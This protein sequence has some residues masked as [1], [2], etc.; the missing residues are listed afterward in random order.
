[1]NEDTNNKRLEQSSFKL[2]PNAGRKDG[3]Q[4]NQSRL[5]KGSQETILQITLD[6]IRHSGVGILYSNPSLMYRIYI[7]GDRNSASRWTSPYTGGQDGMSHSFGNGAQQIG[8]SSYTELDHSS[9]INPCG[10]YRK[11][12]SC[13]PKIYGSGVKDFKFNSLPNP[14]LSKVDA[15]I[16][17]RST[18]DQDQKRVALLSIRTQKRS[19]GKASRICEMASQTVLTINKNHCQFPARRSRHQVHIYMNLV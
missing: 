8:Q 14:L 18:G 5:E 2:S 16:E 13:G 12:T 7:S 9:L 11:L 3:G 6:T 1:M 19:N 4:T 10:S 15:R 17:R